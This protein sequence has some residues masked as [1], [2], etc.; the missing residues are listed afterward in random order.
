VPAGLK[1]GVNITGDNSAAFLLY[2]PYKNSVFVMGDF[3]NWVHSSEGFMKRSPDG[4]WYW[5]EV[6]GLDPA[7]EYAF[8]YLIDE[9]LHI[10]D[11]YSTKCLIRGTTSSLMQPLTLT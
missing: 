7:K 2:A 10:P 8:Q 1:P 6:T 9:S 5:L 3:N 4:N 11:P